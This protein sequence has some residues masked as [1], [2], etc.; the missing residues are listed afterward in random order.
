MTTLRQ[1]LIS[2]LTSTLVLSVS[3]LYAT[4]A[5]HTPAPVSTTVA[6]ASALAS[7]DPT[8]DPNAPALTLEIAVAQ[9]LGAN[10]DVK[11]QRLSTSSSA[12]SEEIA[13]AIVFLASDDSSFMLGATLVVD[14]G[15]AI[16]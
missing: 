9:A 15:H 12:D 13:R 8:E 10:F 2:L 11:L 14:G 16:W 3:A 5:V 7:P 4:D 1:S 6:T